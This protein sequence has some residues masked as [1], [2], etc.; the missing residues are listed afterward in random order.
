MIIWY[1]Q[2]QDERIQ[3]LKLKKNRGT[4]IARN[5]GALFSKGDYIIIPDSDDILSNKIL[6][7]C[8]NLSIRYKYEMIR[9]NQYE[10]RSNGYWMKVFNGFKIHE[11]YQPELS[12]F[13][14]Y[15]LGNL[16]LHDFC[17]SNKFIKRVLF[18]KALNSINQYYLKQYMVG[19]EDCLINFSLHRNAQSLYLLN[20]L[21]YYYIYNNN[22]ITHKKSVNRT[23][24]FRFLYLKFI[25]E[26][27][28]N[29]L[30][31]KDMAFF[32]FNRKLK[33]INSLNI[34]N[35]EFNFYN[36]TLIAYHQFIINPFKCRII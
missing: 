4:L 14:F 21:G 7:I 34:I 19:L 9:F 10:E 6:K 12:T 26:N 25:Y 13:I 24:K 28:K 27:T 29:T 18:I 31:E 20:K 22:S 2:N 8:Y 15:G 35:N 32:V 1:N 5:I 11:I 30:F 3:L 23:L 36:G 17:I 33:N 16:K